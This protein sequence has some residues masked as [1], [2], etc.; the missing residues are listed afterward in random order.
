MMKQIIKSK[1]KSKSKKKKNTS[2]FSLKSNLKLSS[3][4]DHVLMN[5]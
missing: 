2:L 5:S 4:H 3:C 1:S